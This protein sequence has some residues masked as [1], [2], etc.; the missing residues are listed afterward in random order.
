MPAGLVVPED[1]LEDLSRRIAELV[2]GRLGTQEPFLWLDVVG[3]SKY[4]GY[5][6]EGAVRALL[7]RQAIP[8][9][10]AP[11]GRVLFDRR[12]LDEWVRSGGAA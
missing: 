4:L 10:K 9:H 12:E 3:A 6:T 11:N 2:S 7:K 8:H 5:E 1:L